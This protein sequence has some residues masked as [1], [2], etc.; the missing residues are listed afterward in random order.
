LPVGVAYGTRGYQWRTNERYRVVDWTLS[1]YMWIVTN[2]NVTAWRD[3]VLSRARADGV[4]PVFSLNLLDGG[5]KDTVGAWD[6][7][8][9]GGVGTF[10]RYCRMTADQVRSWGQALGPYGCVML[11]WRYDDTFM[12]KSANQSAFRDVSSMLNAKPRRSCKRP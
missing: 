1:Q 5:Y 8:N 4:T 7:P 3:A 9:T 11:A 6:C 10:N 2:G 12:A